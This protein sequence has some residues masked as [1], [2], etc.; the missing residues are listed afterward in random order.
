MRVAVIGAGI[1][2]VS[3]ACELAADGHEVTVL[4]RRGGIAAEASFAHAG[5]IAPGLVAPW[6]AP[7]MPLAILRQRFGRHATV[8]WMPSLDPAQW[9]WLGRW[10]G[11]CRQGPYRA[12]RQALGRLALYSQE[13]LHELSA[14]RAFEYERSDGCLVLLRTARDVRQAEARLPLLKEAGIAFESLSA[15][16]ARVHE[17]A[18]DDT[19]PLAGAIR[20]PGAEVGN[21]RQVAHLLRDLAEQRFNVDF[22]FATTATHLTVT[23]QGPRLRM[24]QLALSTGF[25]ASRLANR[26]RTSR[27]VTARRAAAAARYLDPVN[28]ET[29]DAVVLCGGAGSASLLPALG[30]KVPLLPVHG[31][32]V[33]FPLRAAEHAPRSAVVDEKF[34]ITITRLGDR[35]RVAGISEVGGIAERSHA[36][37][38]E[39]LHT[40]MHDWFPAAGNRARAQTWK[41]ARP[42]L[43]DGLPLI[44]ATPAPGVWLN[45]GHGAHG[46]AL[47]CG[48]A[49]LLADQLM[50]RAPALDIAPFDPARYRS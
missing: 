36:G 22:R 48:S 27:E 33:T 46:W 15:E 37:D 45:L 7:G 6:A 38:L 23:P 32:S 11:A 40:V 43:P 44:G 47:A 20:L 19:P 41:G 29:F 13:R 1:V 21:C 12:H 50:R 42:M 8:R 35:V 24:E 30:L 26:A 34:Q 25:G 49:R 14:A 3:T 10:L 31:Y 5:L 9:R 2:G 28:E 4:D 18:L 39:T 17:P 16:Q